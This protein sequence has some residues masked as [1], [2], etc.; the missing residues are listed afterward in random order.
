MQQN[1][2]QLVALVNTLRALP[3]SNRTPL[4]IKKRKLSI[5]D[6]WLGA[7]FP[8]KEKKKDKCASNCKMQEHVHLYC[9]FYPT[10]MSKWHSSYGDLGVVAAIEFFQEIG[11]IPIFGWDVLN[12]TLVTYNILPNNVVPLLWLVHNVHQLFHALEQQHVNYLYKD[13]YNEEKVWNCLTNSN[14]NETL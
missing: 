5:G 10:E 13:E 11:C 3:Y 12:K 7:S 9:E 1:N 6:S 14:M 8:L 4:P 2:C